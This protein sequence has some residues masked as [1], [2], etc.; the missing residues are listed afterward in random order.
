M[1]D[2]VAMPIVLGLAAGAAFI[3]VITFMSAS[4]GTYFPITPSDFLRISAKLP[5]TREFLNIYPDAKSTVYIRDIVEYSVQEGSQEGDRYAG[6]RIRID[7][8][9]GEAKFMEVRCIVIGMEYD[10]VEM[11]GSKLEGISSFLKDERCPR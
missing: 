5:E 6:L 10:S 7:R 4:Y 1:S 3:F 11:H 9:D 2:S 8:N